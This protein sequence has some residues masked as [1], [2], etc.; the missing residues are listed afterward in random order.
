MKQRGGADD[1]EEFLH[2]RE[3][4]DASDM[5]APGDEGA[6]DTLPC[7]FCRREIWEKADVCSHCGNFVAFPE[8]TIRQ[9]PV[10][11]GRTGSSTSITRSTPAAYLRA[12][13]AAAT[14]TMRT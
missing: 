8:E 9:R 6:E 3:M 10:L 5:D 11:S 12:V 13:S 4:P 2:E 1:D 7:P 14:S